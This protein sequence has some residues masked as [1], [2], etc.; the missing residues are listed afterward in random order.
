MSPLCLYRRRPGERRC[1]RAPGLR[2]PAAGTSPP[3]SASSPSRRVDAHPAGPP[4]AGERRPPHGGRHG[5]HARLAQPVVDALPLARHRQPLDVTRRGHGDLQPGSGG[6]RPGRGLLLRSSRGRAS[7]QLVR[8]GTTAS[9]CRARSCRVTFGPSC[10]AERHVALERP[11]AQLD[12]GHHVA[13]R[14]SPSRPV[15]PG[16]S[17]TGGSSPVPRRPPG[18]PGC[19][20]D[21]L[22]ESVRAGKG[23]DGARRAR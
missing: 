23:Y 5:R 6:L 18:L 19:G 1:A 20:G 14:S 2:R 21:R 7:E 4:A 9:T 12:L 13:S 11:A 8:S 10:R 22:A 15:A 16:A 17:D 3:E